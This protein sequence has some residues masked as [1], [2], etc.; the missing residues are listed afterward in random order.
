MEQEEPPDTSLHSSVDYRSLLRKSIENIAYTLFPVEDHAFIRA[1]LDVPD[2]LDLSSEPSFSSLHEQRTYYRVA[3]EFFKRVQSQI[4]E[5]EVFQTREGR[6]DLNKRFYAVYAEYY[7][8][9]Y[10]VKS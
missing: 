8:R 6:E 10:G 7:R 1:S 2:H 5:H 9:K 4:S 3:S